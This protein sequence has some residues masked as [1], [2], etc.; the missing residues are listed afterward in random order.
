MPE[1]PERF[2]WLHAQQLDD[3]VVSVINDLH[4]QFVAK[5][6][7]C[8]LE[9]TSCVE[10]RGSSDRLWLFRLRYGI[11]NEKLTRRFNSGF[12]EYLKT[13]S[14]H[15][16][17]SN[18]QSN[19]KQ[20]TTLL[21]PLLHQPIERPRTDIGLHAV[22]D[23]YNGMLVTYSYYP[24]GPRM[25]PLHQQTADL[26]RMLSTIEYAWRAVACDCHGGKCQECNG[27]GCYSCFHQDCSNC[28]STGWKNFSRWMQGGFKIN[29]STG[30]PIAEV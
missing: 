11:G 10:G 25:L 18:I 3:T 19:L 30:F 1:R 15:P 12:R 5:W 14:G 27:D 22:N 2:F 24:R 17:L 29:Y 23:V 13:L 9:W 4:H 8:P 26:R 16:K 7:E 6:Q 28:E 21:T 20:R